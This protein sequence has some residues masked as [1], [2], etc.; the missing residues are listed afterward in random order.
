MLR[1]DF[2]GASGI[3]TLKQ[4]GRREVTSAEKLERGIGGIWENC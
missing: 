2:A 4:H 1:R 3:G